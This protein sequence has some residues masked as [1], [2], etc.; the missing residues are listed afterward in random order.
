MGGEE[1]NVTIIDQVTVP[2]EWETCEPLFMEQLLRGRNE[3]DGSLIW[4]AGGVLEDGTNLMVLKWSRGQNWLR[5]GPDTGWAIEERVSPNQPKPVREIWRILVDSQVHA[6]ARA[7]SGE[8][9]SDAEK[10]GVASRHPE[11]LREA[12]GHYCDREE[13]PVPF[14]QFEMAAR[15]YADSLRGES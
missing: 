8:E 5:S 14:E 12:Y 11:M 1:Q 6:A 4:A 9:L 13:N 15:V 3:T 2:R 10:I 7:R